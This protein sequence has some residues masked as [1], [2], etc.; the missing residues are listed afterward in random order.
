MGIDERPVVLNAEPDAIL[1]RGRIYPDAIIGGSLDGIAD[2]PSNDKCKDMLIGG[3][4]DLVIDIVDNDALFTSGL[5]QE[6]PLHPLYETMQGY[7][8]C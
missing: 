7:G 5:W 4:G 3:D 1:R 6:A 2:E 8:G